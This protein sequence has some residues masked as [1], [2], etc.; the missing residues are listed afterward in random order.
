MW[1]V[2]GKGLGNRKAEN[3]LMWKC[4]RD[5]PADAWPS[6]GL[7]HYYLIVASLQVHV[8]LDLTQI[9]RH[10]PYRAY[11][12]NPPHRVRPVD[13]S[14]LQSSV[15]TTLLISFSISPYKHR[16]HYSIILPIHH[17][18]LRWLPEV[19]DHSS[20]G[21]SSSILQWSRDSY[22]YS[23]ELPRAILLRE[24]LPCSTSAQG[25][26]SSGPLVLRPLRLL[27]RSPEL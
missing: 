14:L 11:I 24:T 4:C 6:R 19:H 3:T 13:L 15:F 7:I 17:V 21:A 10:I 25:Q 22:R 5:G 18:L 9:L 2:F 26:G 12:S 1:G 23:G 27:L 16:R 20:A 8:Q